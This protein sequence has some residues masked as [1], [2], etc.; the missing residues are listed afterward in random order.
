MEGVEVSGDY[1]LLNEDGEN[2]RIVNSKTGE[3]IA[4]MPAST[5]TGSN[6]GEIIATLPNYTEGEETEPV[7]DEQIAQSLIQA[8]EDE[9]TILEEMTTG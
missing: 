7:S 3:T 4:T 1:I 2:V 8:M 9:K 6:T 5:L